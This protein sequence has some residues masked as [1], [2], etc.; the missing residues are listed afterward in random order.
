MKKILLSLAVLALVA[1][2]GYAGTRAFF[3]DTE[4]SKANAFTAGAVDIKINTIAATYKD[5]TLPDSGDVPSMEY[6]ENGFSFNLSDLKPLD[7]G[8]VTY[9]L[10]NENN[11]AYVCAKV[12]E[13]GNAE[14]GRNN[15][16]INAGDTTG[17]NPGNGKGELQNFMSFDINGSKGPL[18]AIDGQWF[19]VGTLANSSTLPA[20]IGYCFGQYDTNGDCTIDYGDAE[21]VA[22]TDSMLA[23]VSF[24]AVQKR[25]N[26]NFDCSSLNTPEV[27]TVPVGAILSDYS[28]PEC[29]VSVGDNRTHTTIQSGINSL[30]GDGGVVCVED[31]TYTE[32]PA[33]TGGSQT[34][35]AVNPQGATIDGGA[36]LQF[37][38][39][40]LQGFIIKGTTNTAGVGGV[41]Y[42]VYVSGDNVSV[43]NNK[44]DGSFAGTSLNGGDAPGIVTIYGG[45]TG[46]QITNNVISG[47]SKG[48]F[49]NPSTNAVVKW[50][51]IYGNDGALSSDY[52]V[53]DVVTLNDIHDNNNS[54]VHAAVNAGQSISVNQNNIINNGGA[55][56][57][58]G[59]WGTDSM[60][61]TNNWWGAL[62]G[63]SATGGSGPIVWSPE[64]SVAFPHR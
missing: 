34:I 14:N 57:E 12:D 29:T 48:I 3:S 61:V 54:G 18:S 64:A 26:P 13:A 31:G 58:A 16:E 25:N 42:G 37:D 56:N 52:P 49:L 10:G 38:N 36:K 59:S 4:V 39:D 11:D 40:V 63:A 22:Q 47:F 2:A 32:I 46:L 19:S 20:S 24:Y 17:G 15:P 51:D 33:T 53:G 5:Q 9:E 62:G 1:V 30:N 23:D 28:A 6:T 55:G 44:F 27:S 50:N 45:T 7:W 35:V 60:D 8:K 21:N 43:A 41:G